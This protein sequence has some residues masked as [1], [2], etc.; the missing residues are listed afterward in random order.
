MQVRGLNEMKNKVNKFRNFE[1][2]KYINSTWD[3]A[4]E[5]F[6]WHTKEERLAAFLGLD[7]VKKVPKSFQAYC[8][9]AVQSERQQVST[10]SHDG[11]M[12]NVHMMNVMELSIL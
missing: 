1:S 9:A 8:Q 3:K 2:I 10:L 4:V 7:F 12:A 6:P 11:A 5:R